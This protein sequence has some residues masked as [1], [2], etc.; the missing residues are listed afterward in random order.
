MYTVW[1]YT[2]DQSNPLKP[3]SFISQGI[4]LKASN[5]QWQC[6]LHHSLML[7][8]FI[9]IWRM[10]IYFLGVQSKDEKCLWE[11]DIM[12]SLYSR[13]FWS[14]EVNVLENTPWWNL[15]TDGWWI[16]EI[17]T[18]VKGSMFLIYGGSKETGVEETASIEQNRLYIWEHQLVDRILWMV[19]WR[20]WNVKIFSHLIVHKVGKR[21]E[22]ER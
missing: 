13:V 5:N 2:C 12:T 1:P 21:R 16:A 3:R 6:N 10:N 22:R 7:L 8:R 19:D 9:S 17:Q 14:H 4:W 20:L 11:P 15:D 18:D